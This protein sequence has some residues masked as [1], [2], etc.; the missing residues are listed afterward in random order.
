MKKKT[1]ETEIISFT[2]YLFTRY[3]LAMYGH[4]NRM[5]ASGVS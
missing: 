4:L 2:K 1:P 5:L 3:R